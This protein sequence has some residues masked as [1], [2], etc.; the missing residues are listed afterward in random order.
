MCCR[1]QFE[2]IKAST[3][4]YKIII[5]KS[6]I[7]QIPFYYFLLVDYQLTF[8]K[9]KC[10]EILYVSCARE[11]VVELVDWCSCCWLRSFIAN[12]MVPLPFFMNGFHFL[13]FDWSIP[14]Q[15]FVSMTIFIIIPLCS[16]VNGTAMSHCNV[17]LPMQ[18]KLLLLFG[19]VVVL[20]ALIMHDYQ[21]IQMW[22]HRY[23]QDT[24]GMQNLNSIQ[25]QYDF[26]ILALVYLLGSFHLSAWLCKQTKWQE[27]GT[28]T[29]KSSSIYHHCII[30]H[31]ISALKISWWVR[32]ENLLTTDCWHI[33]ILYVKYSIIFNLL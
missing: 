27:L 13:V 12:D 1:M 24:L 31:V 21:N 18:G 26:D 9:N 10:V 7:W 6:A 23:N 2:K 8:E 20:K 16:K 3:I 30:N 28:M 14:H 22:C 33:S 32:N 19:E 11:I 17:Y 15:H 29:G 5:R 4:A 25:I